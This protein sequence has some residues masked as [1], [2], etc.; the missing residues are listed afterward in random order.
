ML[1]NEIL[2]NEIRKTS[3]KFDISKKNLKIIKKEN[4]LNLPKKKI[5]EEREYYIGY[6]SSHM[7]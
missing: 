2:L 6:D 4:I 3:G 1:Y 7:F 5:M